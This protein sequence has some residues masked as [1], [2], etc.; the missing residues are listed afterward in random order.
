M[1]S[2][3]KK[4]K[5]VLACS[6][7]ACYSARSECKSV[8]TSKNL[9][10]ITFWR[11]GTLDSSGTT[12]YCG[13]E[14]AKTAFPKPLI[15]MCCTKVVEIT[16]ILHPTDTLYLSLVEDRS[17][18]LLWHSIQHTSAQDAQNLRR[19]SGQRPHLDVQVTNGRFVGCL[20]KMAKTKDIRG[21]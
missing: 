10:S 12:G 18:F 6:T 15:L 8:A 14:S 17:I 11:N 2:I 13:A 4:E 16:S 5:S 7:R 19:H 21:D 3:L 20:E 1:W 9:D